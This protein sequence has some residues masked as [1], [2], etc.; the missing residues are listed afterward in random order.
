MCRYDRSHESGIRSWHATLTFLLQS[1]AGGHYFEG[2]RVAERAPRVAA[3]TSLAKFWLPAQAQKK[4]PVRG[5]QMGFELLCDAPWLPVLL[6]WQERFPQLAPR[7]IRV[8]PQRSEAR[9][10][11]LH[12]A[13]ACV[14]VSLLLRMR[15]ATAHISF[16][17]TLD[18]TALLC[19]MMQL[20]RG[21]TS[22]L[23]F[24]FRPS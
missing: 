7:H 1:R 5:Q 9:R 24:S 3:N 8:H 20:W 12:R 21:R 19:R 23:R 4:S 2:A 13:I 17:L 10:P 6:Q 22:P 15:D 18:Q 16:A 14:D 11:V